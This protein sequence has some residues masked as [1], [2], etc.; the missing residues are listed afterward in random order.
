MFFDPKKNKKRL[1]RHADEIGLLSG[2]TDNFKEN[3]QDF[4]TSEAW[5]RYVIEKVLLSIDPKLDIH[6]HP[7]LDTFDADFYSGGTQIQLEAKCRKCSIGKYDTTNI[8]Y[9]KGDSIENANGWLLVFFN[10]GFD[11]LI[12]DLRQYKPSLGEWTKNHYTA[13]GADLKN[14][15]EKERC[16]KFDISKA[17]YRGKF[18]GS[19]KAGDS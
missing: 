5:A 2:V 4:I 18:N 7:Q 12:F 13:E 16:W 11:W 19:G 10:D 1:W 6:Q 3:R 14:Y 17:I 15:R 9:K 8:S